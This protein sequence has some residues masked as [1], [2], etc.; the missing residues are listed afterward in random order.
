MRVKQDDMLKIFGSTVSGY[1][2]M[3]ALGQRREGGGVQ[4]GDCSVA[5]VVG[6]VFC[7]IRTEPQTPEQEAPCSLAPLDFCI[8]LCLMV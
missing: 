6:C 8:L 5:S 4:H 2:Q 3:D 7:R 1:L